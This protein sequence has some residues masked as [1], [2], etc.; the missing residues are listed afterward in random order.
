MLCEKEGVGCLE[1]FTRVKE[2][3]GGAFDSSTLDEEGREIS[4]EFDTVAGF[5]DGSAEPLTSGVKEISGLFDF[6]A[7]GE[8][9]GEGSPI[10]TLCDGLD[11]GCF[12]FAL[13]DGVTDGEI[14]FP[15]VAA[16]NLEGS[17][18]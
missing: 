14:D 7:E 15:L 11:D 16:P 18:V 12:R 10:L 9:E 1:F 8:A 13:D 3:G 2:D 6:L 5:E 17:A 4:S